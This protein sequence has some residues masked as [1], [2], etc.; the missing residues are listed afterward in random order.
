MCLKFLERCMTAQIM[1]HNAVQQTELAANDGWSQPG[2]TDWRRSDAAQLASGLRDIRSRTLAVFDAYVAAGSLDVRYASELNPPLWEL[3]HVGWYQELWIGRNPQRNAGIRYDHT[4]L[5]SP[6]LLARADS[7]YDSGTVPH[8]SRWHL[9]L[10]GADACK[11]YLAATLEQTLALLAVAGQSDDA[12]YFYR[13]V[14]FH[15]A[16]HLEAAIYMAQALGVDLGHVQ[17]LYTDTTKIIAN[18]PIATSEKCSIFFQNTQ[19]TLGS[20]SGGTFASG[21]A[22]DNELGAHSVALGPYTIDTQPVSWREY[23][24]YVLKTGCAL[25]RYVR[26]TPGG[27]EQQVWGQ[28]QVIDLGQAAVHISYAEALA[29]CAYADRRLPTEAEW[30]CAAVS[31]PEQFAWGDVWEWTASTFAPYPGF[32]VHPYLDYSEPWFHTR[33]VLRGACSATQPMMRSVKYRNY[34]MPQR[35]DI[36][37]GFRTCAL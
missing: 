16:M 32:V 17:R 33:P 12:L 10:L 7:W 29:Y 27:Y 9:P 25:P 22:F 5:R 24:G 28:W 30:E 21:F 3:G 26:E 36:Y 35:T 14:L 15:E 8:A 2:P 37:A 13:L 34:F 1:R 20:A 6:S 23:L 18:Y 31:Q 11:A 19:W 4:A